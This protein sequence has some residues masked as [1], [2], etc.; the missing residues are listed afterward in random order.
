MDILDLMRTLGSKTGL[1]RRHR[2]AYAG[3][4]G[5]LI[6]VLLA[7]AYPGS[8]AAAPIAIAS[9][10][11]LNQ[12]GA[13]ALSKNLT[14]AGDCLL[15]ARDH[16]TIDLNGFEIAGNGSGSGIRFATKCNCSGQNITIRNGSIVAF[17]RGIDLTAIGGAP[18]TYVV[19]RMR[20]IRN[21]ELG[22][23]L[24]SQSI[25]KDSVFSA[26]G[27]CIFTSGC[28]KP[29]KAGDGLVVGDTSVV[30]GNVSAR[31]AGS[32]IVAGSGSTVISNSTNTNALNGIVALESTVSQNT[33]RGNGKAGLVVTCPAN[34][35]GNLIIKN[36]PNLSLSGSGCNSE[37]NEAP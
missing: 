7:L 12:P 18:S 30:T 6:L 25:V 8:A 3:V 13:Y 14:A 16:V 15:I 33:A 2:P 37:H 36:T 34:L 27:T 4:P 19:E 35:I 31:N 21:S 32:G 23:E 9:C 5:A 20:I 1:C 10:Q 28:P 24:G 26:N 17:A 29:T 22:V 11:T